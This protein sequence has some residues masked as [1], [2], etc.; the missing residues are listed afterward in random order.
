[1]IPHR[2]LG[3][4]LVLGMA[5]ASLPAQELQFGLERLALPDM[6]LHTEGGQLRLQPDSAWV[7]SLRGSLDLGA[8]GAWTLG[9]SAALS[10]PGDS[11]LRF[12]SSAPAS[13]E[14]A[15]FNWGWQPALGAFL[16]RDACFGTALAAGLGLELRRESYEV[17]DGGQGSPAR[18]QRPWARVFLRHPF[19]PRLGGIPFLSL[20][21]AFPLT[22]PATP[23]AQAYLGDLDQLGNSPAPGAAAQTHAPGWSLTFALGIRASNSH[24]PCF[25]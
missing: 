23:S 3:I 6:T 22:A 14:V 17:A 16:R 12:E 24:F 1:M 7:P 20:E 4:G 18:L 2:L 25:R 10:L 15:R 9:L 8:R 19:A 21:A 5:P 11:A 13:G